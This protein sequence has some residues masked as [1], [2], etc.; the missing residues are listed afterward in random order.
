MLIL[1]QHFKIP[2]PF[3]PLWDRAERIKEGL[4]VTLFQLNGLMVPFL[5]ISSPHFLICRHDMWLMLKTEMWLC[6]PSVLVALSACMFPVCP[7]ATPRLVPMVMFRSSQR[8]LGGSCHSLYSCGFC[9]SETLFVFVHLAAFEQYCVLHRYQN[10]RTWG[11]LLSVVG[12]DGVFQH[13]R[14]DCGFVF[15]SIY[16]NGNDFKWEYL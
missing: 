15:Q 6:V 9:F 14:K 7:E 3:S 16:G 10:L 11:S 13:H 8:Y 12:T 4:E 2:S 5:Q 1:R